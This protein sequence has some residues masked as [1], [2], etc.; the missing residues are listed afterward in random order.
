V[1]LIIAQMLHGMAVA[2]ASGHEASKTS[3][4]APNW[5]GAEICHHSVLTRLS[6]IGVS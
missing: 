6:F 5:L 1:A 2:A 4:V 3:D